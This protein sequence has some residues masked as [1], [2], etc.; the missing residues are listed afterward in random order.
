[1]ERLDRRSAP[2]VGCGAD[3]ARRGSVEVGRGSCLMSCPVVVFV[4]AAAGDLV[5]GRDS[6]GGVSSSN[7]GRSGSTDADSL[8]DA[9]PPFVLDPTTG[10]WAVTGV[11]SADK[12][13]IM[14]SSTSLFLAS[15]AFLWVVSVSF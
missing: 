7:S 12:P 3:W 11:D 8:G 10:L 5:S 4:G 15:M 9:A 2:A 1:M 14:P 6:G 13:R